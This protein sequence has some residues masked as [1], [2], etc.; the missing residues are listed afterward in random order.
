MRDVH[1]SLSFKESD[2]NIDQPWRL[3]KETLEK[4]F[5]GPIGVHLFLI[6]CISF[7]ISFLNKYRSRREKYFLQD[8]E[9]KQ[10]YRFSCENFYSPFS[11]EGKEIGTERLARGNE[12][13]RRI[14]EERKSDGIKHE[15]ILV[16][17]GSAS[18]IKM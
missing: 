4:I 16:T 13:K 3:K 9:I 1:R 12:E 11:R 8:E 7:Q 5:I 17:R 18:T 2:E 6:S 15:V 14:K 10:T